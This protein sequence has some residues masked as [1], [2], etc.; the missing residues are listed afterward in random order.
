MRWPARLRA[1]G[2]AVLFYALLFAVLAAAWVVLRTVLGF[3]RWPTVNEW[4]L[5]ALMLIVFFVLLF[6]VLTLLEDR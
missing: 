1:C 2:V 6:M 3:L 4:G 5:I